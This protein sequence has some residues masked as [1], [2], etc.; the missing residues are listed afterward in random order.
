MLNYIFN[1]EKHNKTFCST[2]RS[3]GFSRPEWPQKSSWATLPSKIYVTCWRKDIHKQQLQSCAPLRKNVKNWVLNFLALNENS[4][5]SFLSFMS[6][7]FKQVLLWNCSTCALVSLPQWSDWTGSADCGVMG[8]EVNICL[9]EETSG[10]WSEILVICLHS[11]VN[12]IV[13]WVW[14]NTPPERHAGSVA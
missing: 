12:L 1:H 13:I 8:L 14:A 7:L 6:L 3:P 10:P 11:C 5:S 9:R 2:C 4:C